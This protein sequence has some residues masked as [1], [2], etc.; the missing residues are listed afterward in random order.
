ML[1]DY[2]VRHVATENCNRGQGKVDL[3]S[4]GFLAFVVKLKILS[5]YMSHK[6][7]V[8]TLIFFFPSTLKNVPKW[9][10]CEKELKRF[11][12]S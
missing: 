3:E 2:Y 9:K 4:K 1:G 11:K 10:N 6:L 5:D 8:A 7:F 12:K